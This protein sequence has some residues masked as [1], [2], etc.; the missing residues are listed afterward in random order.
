MFRHALTWVT[1]C[2]RGNSRIRPK[3]RQLPF[4]RSTK[5]M[6]TPTLCSRALPATKGD[7]A[8]ALTQIQHALAIDPNRANFH[9][10]LGMLQSGDP[11]TAAAGEDQLRK[12]V[13][14]DGK[15]VAAHLVLASLLQKKGDLQGAES[16]MK[17]AVAADPKSVMARVN[18]ADL[19]VRENNNAKAEESLRQASEDLSDSE[20][21]AG[22]LATYYIRNNQTRGR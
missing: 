7:R 9:A 14:L 16:E 6:R 2:S 1:S 4:W 3:R 17:A 5:T 12:A 11:A 15:N 21:G 19:Y 22:M 18:L 13:A 10:S 20:Y 8:E